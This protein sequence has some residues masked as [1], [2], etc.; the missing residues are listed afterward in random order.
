MAKLARIIDKQGEAYV[1]FCP[2]CSSNHLIP[3]RYEAGF[4]KRSGKKKPVWHFNDNSVWP[5]FKPAFVVEWVGKE[6]PQRCSVII[7]DG[8]LIYL[9]DSTHMLAGRRINMGD[10]C[11]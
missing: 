8:V 6:P 5:T 7:R 2:G 1:F 11:R 3:V 4:E 10:V 9:I